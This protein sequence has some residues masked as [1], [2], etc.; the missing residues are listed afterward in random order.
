LRLALTG[1]GAGP[2][3]FDVVSML[4]KEEVESRIKKAIA[5]LG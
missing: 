5:E 3:L 2:E 4:G 1:M